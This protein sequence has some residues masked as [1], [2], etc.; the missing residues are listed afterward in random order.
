M[1]QYLPEN[2][3]NLNDVWRGLLLPET[4]AAPHDSTVLNIDTLLS[5]VASSDQLASDHS[6]L[7]TTGIFPDLA[8]DAEITTVET[9]CP[10]DGTG[11]AF[12]DLERGSQSRYNTM[13]D[14]GSAISV[15]S[16]AYQ[17]G[18][19]PSQPGAA[20]A[21]HVM[22]QASGTAHEGQSNIRL[23]PESLQDLPAVI[24]LSQSYPPQIT[25]LPLPYLPTTSRLGRN[26]T[27]HNGQRPWASGTVWEEKRERISRLWLT[28]GLTVK[29][30]R[31]EMEKEGFFAT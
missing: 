30:V 21:S 27:D 28:D 22:D 3:T 6:L 25:P 31:S 15:L 7:A 1:E 13:P 11:Q 9:L 10:V 16:P 26:G 18:S 12:S 20:I 19:E 14:L 29:E 5:A 24:D 17:L 4:D 23:E 2:C 8:T